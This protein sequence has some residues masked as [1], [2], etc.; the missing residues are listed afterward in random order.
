MPESTVGTVDGIGATILLELGRIGKDVAVITEAMKAVPDHETRLRSL[1][2]QAAQDK[3]G[4][5]VW[6]RVAG[7]LAIAAAAASGVAGYIHH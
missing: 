5:D 1:E 2:T 3:G 7:G 6:A 4:K